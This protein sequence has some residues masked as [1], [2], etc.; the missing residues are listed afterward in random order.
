MLWSSPSNIS[1]PVYGKGCPASKALMSSTTTFHRE[2]GYEARGVFGKFACQLTTSCKVDL[3]KT[4]SSKMLQQAQ[5]YCLA[6]VDSLVHSEN[7]QL[8]SL[9]VEVVG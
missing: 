7:I 3:T 9:H 6:C 5:T 2:H 1:K 4:N 8:T